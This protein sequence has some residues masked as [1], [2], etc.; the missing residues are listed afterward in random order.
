[1]PVDPSNP[2]SPADT[3]VAAVGEELRALKGRIN[4]LD[5]AQSQALQEHKDDPEAHEKAQVGLGNV[6]NLS[7]TYSPD[8]A[9]EDE[10]TYAAVSYV[11][12]SIAQV[13]TEI[14]TINSTLT[15]QAGTNTSVASS[16][17]S[18]N[19]NVSS[20]SSDVD[21]LTTTAVSNSQRIGDIGDTTIVYDGSD[22]SLVSYA[23][24]SYKV[25]ATYTVKYSGTVISVIPS[26]ASIGVG[27]WIVQGGV[28]DFSIRATRINSNTLRFEG[29]NGGSKLNMIFNWIKLSDFD[30]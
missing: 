14:N 26:F 16:I 17:S 6:I 19:S 3:E 24:T 20:L 29:Y 8:A 28:G 30:V 18:L 2:N 1:M 21:N 9:P 13:N 22:S 11:D 4:S 10:E 27:D 25:G 15:S 12:Y 5:S 23:D 7:V